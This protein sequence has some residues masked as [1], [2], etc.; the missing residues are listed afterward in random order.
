MTLALIGGCRREPAP[1]PGASP[2]PRAA[3]RADL[4]DFFVKWLEGHGHTDVVVDAEGVG[5]KDNATRLQA[6]LYGSKQSQKGGFV[7]EVEFTVQLPAG[8]AITEYV[9][10]MGD[11]EEKAIND[12][13]ANFTITTFHVVYKAFM[14]ADDPHMTTTSLE[15]DGVKREVIAGDLMTRG[16]GR[17]DKKQAPAIRAE[18]LELLKKLQV[19]SGAHWIKVVY[20][21]NNGQV[22]TAAATIDNV[23]D[24]ELTEAL[25]RLNWPKGGFYMA[26]EF[27]IILPAAEP[28]AAAPPAKP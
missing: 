20:G 2:E 28:Q 17:E 27:I 10:G 25:K 18:I 12:A 26:K 21:Q 1:M 14:N 19:K 8:G 15:I 4:D 11:T 22:I 23:A 6:G 7:V 24:N 9:A 13:L 16:S 5:I 3:R